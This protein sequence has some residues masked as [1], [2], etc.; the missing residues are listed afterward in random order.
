MRRCLLPLIAGLIGSVSLVG[1]TAIPP[2]IASAVPLVIAASA[3]PQDQAGTLLRTAQQ[4]TATGARDQALATLAQAEQLARQIKDATQQDQILMHIAAEYAKLNAYERAIAIGQGMTYNS[5][6]PD[7]C[8][9]PLR[10]EVEIAIARAYLR[11]GQLEPAQ[12]LVQSVPEGMAKHQVL[13]AIIEE[14]AA[15]QRFEEAIALS[16]TIVND[17]PQKI[18]AQLAIHKGYIGAGQWAEAWALSQTWVE[19]RDRANAQ[20]SLVQWVTRAGQYA[21]A[22]RMA[23]Q[24]ATLDLRI[25]A[26]TEL[27]QAQAAVGQQAEALEVLNQAYQMARSQSEPLSITQWA[28]FFA[29]VGAYERALEIAGQSDSDYVRADARLYVALAYAQA[30]QYAQALELAETVREGELQPFADFPDPKVNLLNEVVK[31]A[32]RTGQPEWAMRAAQAFEQGDLKAKALQAIA[33]HALANS[34]PERAIQVLDQA[35]AAAKTVESVLIVLDRNTLY[36]EPNAGLLLEIAQTYT[37]LGQPAQAIAIADLAAQSAQ[38]FDY[39]SGYYTD[40]ASR[41]VTAL[42]QVAQFYAASGQP[43]KAVELLN[44][45][46]PLAAQAEGL[47][48]QMQAHLEIAEGYAI[49]QQP[50]L[51]RTALAKAEQ[52]NQGSVDVWT[53]TRLVKAYAVLGQ[54]AQAVETAQQILQ[55]VQAS[56]PNDVPWR[57]HQLATALAASET[58]VHALRLTETLTEPGQ[59]IS[60]LASMVEQYQLAN[61]PNQANQVFDQLFRVLDG[62]WN[63]G[64]RNN[65]LKSLIGIQYAPS[66]YT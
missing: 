1:N 6:A 31:Q 59:Q 13:V 12:Q 18:L 15:Q 43:G 26:F 24:I 21:E 66:R 19:S 47:A 56:E 27:A 62:I 54:E 28:N 2:A 63:S 8:C 58:P 57:T 3:T 35:L 14:L 33:Q 36:R 61:R 29:Q 38:A 32:S 5:Y 46:V 50:D 60:P 65:Y 20:Y 39:T 16:N 42:T 40:A 55:Q 45:V 44:T 7:Y 41:K 34:Q 51:A 30:G 23:A 48:R 4:L 64:Q 11:S 9:V 52:I 22:H 53:L 37:E 17:Y 49:A 10:T 25:Q